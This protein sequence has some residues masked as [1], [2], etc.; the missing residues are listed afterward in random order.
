MKDP[1]VFC[2]AH[3][4]SSTLMKFFFLPFVIGGGAFLVSMFFGHRQLLLS[5]D[6]T[7]ASLSRQTSS[8]EELR[9]NKIHNVQENTEFWWQRY[10][11]ESKTKGTMHLPSLPFPLLGRNDRAMLEMLKHLGIQSQNHVPMYYT[12]VDIGLPFES[13]MFASSGFVV[14][15]FEAR[16]DGAAQVQKEIDT[17]NLQNMITLH[18]TALS[19]IT[20]TT[21]DL[22]DAS[23]SSSLLESAVEG[24]PERRKF[25]RSGR[26]KETVPVNILDAFVNQTF[27]PESQQ[28]TI[29]VGIKIDTQ[30]SEP[31]I[32]MGAENL[33]TA[34]LTD[35]RLGPFVIIMEYCSR[36]RDFYELSVG[37][38]LL[39]GLGFACYSRKDPS[40]IDIDSEFCGDIVC[41]RHTN[42]T[43]DL[44]VSAEALHVS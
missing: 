28:N 8:Y 34:G 16:A 38:H 9:T 1:F 14:H 41:I 17:K 12:L 23:D 26:K 44:T 35:P 5:L 6:A 32:L 20:N 40:K 43:L 21:L 24:G 19:N 22:Y 30:G 4:K 15:A 42:W 31:E 33:L 37:P 2:H 7:E 3:K 10:V 18:H 29:V 11:Q 39:R 25:M 13:L 36:L 27:Q